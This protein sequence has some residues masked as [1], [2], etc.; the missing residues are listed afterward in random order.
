MDIVPKPLFDVALGEGAFGYPGSAGSFCKSLLRTGRE[1]QGVVISHHPAVYHGVPHCDTTTWGRA[2]TV[3]VTEPEAVIGQRYN[4]P[5]AERCRA[6]RF[7][8]AEW[9]QFRDHI[10]PELSEERLVDA[11]NTLLMDPDPAVRGAAAVA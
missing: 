8:P 11:Y 1:S 5:S 9:R 6:T 4:T 10:P 3:L 7:F 2:G